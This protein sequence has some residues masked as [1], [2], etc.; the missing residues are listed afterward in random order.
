[1]HSGSR[2]WGADATKEEVNTKT[3]APRATH[4]PYRWQHKCPDCGTYFTKRIASLST[5]NF[6]GGDECSNQVVSDTI[7]NKPTPMAE[8][9]TATT[10]AE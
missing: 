7:L 6:C 9:A 8:E 4:G 2:G 5:E 3:G 10:A 1:M